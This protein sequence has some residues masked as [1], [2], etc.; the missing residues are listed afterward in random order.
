M[1][2][3]IESLSPVPTLVERSFLDVDAWAKFLNTTGR[4]IQIDQLSPGS[5]HADVWF[6]DFG[7]LQVGFV[8]YGCPMFQVGERRKHFI[9]FDVLLAV[10]SGAKR[11]Q[12]PQSSSLSL[13]SAL[14]F[15]YWRYRGHF[16]K[17]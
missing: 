3:F 7:N 6:A 5:F 11:R 16:L 12:A 4:Q 14:G 15:S 8:K 17:S 10:G 9:H 13:V 2:G 1:S